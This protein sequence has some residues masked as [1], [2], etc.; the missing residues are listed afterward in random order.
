[1]N[2]IFELDIFLNTNYLNLNLL[3]FLDILSLSLNLAASSS[4]APEISS[5]F[6]GWNIVN[7]DL[8]VLLEIISMTWVVLAPVLVSSLS[9][10]LSVINCQNL[11]SDS[12]SLSLT[13]SSNFTLYTAAHFSNLSTETVSMKLRTQPSA[14][15]SSEARILIFCEQ[16]AQ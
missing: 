3:G 7:S 10:K 12:N 11:F 9:S 15:H 14:I 6:I 1:M 5:L 16:T 13:K 2:S 4:F 8:G